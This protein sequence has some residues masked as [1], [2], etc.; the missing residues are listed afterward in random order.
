MKYEIKGGQL[1]VAICT[2]DRG[3]TMFTESGGMA[4]MSAGMSYETN[5]KGG[6]GKGL[7][8]MLAGESLFMTT[9]AANADNQE[10]AFASS[11]PGKIMA[12]ELKPGE[13]VIVQKKAFLAAESSVSVEMHFNKKLGAGLLGGEGFILQKITGPGVCFLEIDGDVVEKDLAPGEVLQIDQGHLAMFEP[14]VNF[15]ITTVKGV[16]NMFFGGEG[17]FLG[18][19]VGPGKVYLQTMPFSNLINEIASRLPS[20]K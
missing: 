9:Y 12:L 11:F 7:G 13:T 17:L 15:D 16:K 19:L 18:K 20:S 8:R 3:E 4:W 1:P 10:I 5:T 14:T 6:L 2:L